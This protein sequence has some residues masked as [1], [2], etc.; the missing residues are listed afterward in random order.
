VKCWGSANPTT[1][2]QKIARA[3]RQHACTFDTVVYPEPESV[4]DFKNLERAFLQ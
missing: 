1:A 4:I 3:G 2:S